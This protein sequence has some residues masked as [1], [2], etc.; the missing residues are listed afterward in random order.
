MDLTTIKG[1]AKAR[2]WIL[3]GAAILA[4]LVSGRLA[5]YRNDNLPGY[6]AS[7]VITFVE[8]LAA[9]DRDEFET[10]L[11]TQF[12]LAQDVNSDVLT[13]TPGTFIPWLLAE[14]QL[15][16]DLNQIVFIG[17]GFTQ[18]EATQLTD[19]MRQRFL[20]TSPIGAGQERLSAELDDLTEQIRVLR[21]EINEATRALPLTEDQLGLTAQR[22]AAETRI[23]ALQAQYGAL[24]VELM[25]PV[26]RSGAEIQ[27][28]MDRVYAEFLRLQIELA[29]IPPPPTQEELAAG[30]EELLLDQLR[31][32]QLQARW[33]Q[34]YSGQRDLE[35]RASESPAVAQPVTLDAASPLNNQALALFG[36]IAAALIGLIA[37]ERG[38]GIMWAESDLEEGPPVLVE[39]PSRPLAVFRHPTTDPWYLATPGGRR[40][41]AVQMLRSQLDDHDNAVVAFQGSG[42]FREDIREL[43]GDVAVAIAVSGRSVLL[44]DASFQEENDLV[45]FGSDHGATLSSLLTDASGDRE[46]A[47]IDFKTALLA[48]PELVAGLR[49]LRAGVGEWDAADALSGY[50][51]EILMDVA[52]E[53]FDLVLIA[54][55]N[56]GEAASH[57]LAQRVDSVIL[58]T[59]AGHTVSRSVEA[60]DREFSIRRATLLGVVLL[61]RR[62]NKV[63]RW[64][65]VG[66]RQRLWSGLNRFADWRH[67]TFDKP[68]QSDD[69]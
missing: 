57:V 17:R 55:S 9:A 30:D 13:E 53:L 59:S 68:D 24:G 33:T 4:V 37:I 46:S 1:I 3:V 67:R 51:F 29:A 31:L 54:G 49:T 18:E 62:R 20:S 63:S 36:A 58:V 47:I 23:A 11:D 25:N 10:F 64:F 61:R 8:D 14:V 22:A 45:E 12:N 40:K 32:E 43:T 35:A 56:V 42:V 60:T 41:A 34:L 66:L 69:D 48:S 44:I 52:R 19:V 21:Q 27:A 39:L 26:L 16:T 7:S 5:D 2:W 50:G 38:R 65:G 6:E 28:E 15:N